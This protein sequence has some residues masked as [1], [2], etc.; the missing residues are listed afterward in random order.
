MKISIQYY[1]VFCLL[2]TETLSAQYKPKN[3]S[4]SFFG[5][6]FDVHANEIQTNLGIGLNEALIDSFLWIV[7]PDYIQVDCKGHSGISSYPTLSGF[8][9]SGYSGNPMKL[10]REVTD[11]HKVALYV[12]FSGIYD[13]KVVQEFPEWAIVNSQGVK[14]NK[15]CSVYSPYADKYLI[16]QLKELA[17]EYKV[18]GAWID[19]ECWAIEPDYG[20]QSSLEFKK[21]TGIQDLPKNPSEPGYNEFM[22]F[23][24]DLFKKHV[25]HYLTEVHK[26][27]PDFQITSNW[28]FSSMMPEKVSLDLDFLSGDLTPGN[29]VYRA[30]F[31]SRC[32]A[33]Q[34]K[35]WDIMAWSFSWDPEGNLP[36]NQKSALQ[37]K[38]ELAEVLAMGGGVQVYFKQN[39]DLSIQPWTIPIMKELADFCRERQN[40]CFQSKP[41][42]EIALLYSEFSYKQGLKDIYPEWDPSLKS[43]L[44]TLNLLM[45]N[46]LSV[47]ITMEH[48][49][50]ENLHRFPMIVIPNWDTLENSLKQ[51]LLD[52]TEQGGKLL[53]SGIGPVNLVAKE[54]G[55][56]T[57]INHDYNSYF[58]GTEQSM[59][60]LDEPLL[61]L[62]PTT[63]PINDKFFYSKNDKRYRTDWNSFIIQ[64]YGEGMIGMIAFDIGTSYLNFPNYAKRIFMGEILN[65]MLLS[66]QVYVKGS[67]KVHLVIS[68]HSGKKQL[69][70][71][72]TSGNHANL[73]EVGFNEVEPLYNL[74][75]SLQSNEKPRSLVQQPGGEKLKFKYQDGRIRFVLKQLNLYKIIELN[76][77]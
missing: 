54:L 37:L 4:E 29:A 49:L 11:K 8:R 15:I 20:I 56:K 24:R 57:S 53:L 14:S 60:N 27:Y 7:K 69:H 41:V 61:I 58:T 44:G 67:S 48:Y 19:G 71:I 76:Y 26:S 3:R 9:A 72:N 75:I 59:F 45:D 33:L 47:E 25:N 30:A 77:E 32:M 22:E 46:Q 38:Q 10:W 40:Y 21:R 36:R 28:A 6:H 62:E 18:D 70:L 5:I 51:Q 42:H 43:I 55:I 23:Q 31:E 1:V 50:K 73:N 66:R 34:G 74:I 13:R 2:L 16:P 39:D 64:N 35:P 17:E 12:H 68:E 52:Y 63:P 65:T